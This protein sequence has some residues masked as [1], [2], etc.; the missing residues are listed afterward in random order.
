MVKDEPWMLVLK[1]LPSQFILVLT[2][3]LALTPIPGV[4]SLSQR[5]SDP[6]V[7]NLGYPAVPRA[8]SGIGRNA[9]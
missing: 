6:F 8:A 1:Q 2:V 3:A 4:V 7:E 9:R 5:A